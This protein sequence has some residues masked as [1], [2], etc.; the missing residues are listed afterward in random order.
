MSNVTDNGLYNAINAP[1]AFAAIAYNIVKLQSQI[2]Q[3][4]LP[5]VQAGRL[6]RKTWLLGYLGATEG[7]RLTGF[8]YKLLS[9]INVLVLLVP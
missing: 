8:R 3:M 1:D 5:L 6:N 9:Y 2:L 7:E 4:H